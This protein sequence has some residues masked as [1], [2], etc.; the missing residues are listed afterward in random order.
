MTL[1]WP[2]L[3]RLTRPISFQPRHGIEVWIDRI[4]ERVKTFGNGG[5]HQISKRKLLPLGGEISTEVCRL[6]PVYP[7]GCNV[8]G[9]PQTRRNPVRLF[10]AAESQQNFGNNGTDEGNA[11]MVQ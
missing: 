1:D 9:K 5:H 3:F 6:T 7:L 11:I 2:S 4:D 8:V 10:F